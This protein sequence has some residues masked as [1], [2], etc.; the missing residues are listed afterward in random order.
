M[1]IVGVDEAG[2][3]PLAGPVVAAAVLLCE[4]GIDG[5]DDSKKL[6]AKR[7]GELEVLIK[8]RCRWGVGE[9]S[10]AEI[11]R[12][13]ILQATFLAMT[14]AVEALGFDP[15][16]VLVDGNRLPKWRYSARA[17]V[18][19]D[20]LHPCISAASIIAK[21]HHDRFMVAAARDY[22]GF[23]WDRNMGYGTPE[24]MTALRKHGPTPHHRASFAP[25]AQLMLI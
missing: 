7:R 24:H 12:I 22:P 5:L 25:V 1:L 10:V 17:I 18:G 9:A 11:D 19:G 23:G 6:T 20:A 16:E 21:E 3:G 2:R 13:N 8:A 15:H 4:G 14:R